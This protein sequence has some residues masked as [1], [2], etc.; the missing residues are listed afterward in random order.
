MLQKETQHWDT[1]PAFI[2]AITAIL[3]GSEAV[4]N[5]SV[6]AL[7]ASYEAPFEAIQA[8]G[9]G[10]TV[11]RKFFREVVEERVYDDKTG[12]ND[13]VA[14]WVPLQPGESV[15]VG[16]KIRVEYAIWNAENRSFVKLTAG[17][18]ASL[19]PVEQLSGHLGWGLLRP[20]RSGY[21]WTFT[22]NG[23]RNVKASATEYYFDSY[24]EESTVLAEEFFVTQAGRFTAPVTVIESLYAPHYRANSAYR[25]ALLSD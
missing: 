4:L 5:T 24:P 1:E 20:L 8:T 14:Q 2:D 22:P 12:P 7:S 11:E 19:R 15:E 6:L 23:Y 10:F 9:N 17:R 25:P 3:D 13:R 21:S 16:D 18:E